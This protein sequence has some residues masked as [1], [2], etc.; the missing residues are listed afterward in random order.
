MKCAFITLLLGVSV[1]F[2]ATAQRN[3]EPS[4]VGSFPR[5]SWNIVQPDTSNNAFFKK[6]PFVKSIRARFG[7]NP[8]NPFHLQF[9][10]AMNHGRLGDPFAMKFEDIGSAPGRARACQSVTIS[11]V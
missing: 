5:L 3:R 10:S 11:M 4:V 8:P 6:Y 1:L 2:T 7:A 9:D